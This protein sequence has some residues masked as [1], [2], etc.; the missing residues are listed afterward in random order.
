ML[1]QGAMQNQ[2]EDPVPRNSLMRLWPWLVVLFVLLF[3]GFIR[4]R[5]LDMPLERDEGEFAYAGQLLLQGVSPY[6]AAYNVALKLPGTFV[7]YA[8]IMAVFGQTT[9]AIHAGV[10]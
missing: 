7:S 9:I 8:A 2:T 5:L 1:F 3:V 10:I 6:E 4:V